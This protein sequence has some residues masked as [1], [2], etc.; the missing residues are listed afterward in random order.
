MLRSIKEI[1]GY[2]IH[3]EDGKFGTVSD[4]YFDDEHWMVRYLVVDTGKWLPGRKVLLPPVVLDRPR[5][6]KKELPVK[7]T[8]KKIENSPPITMDEPV[9]R[10]FEKELN[11]Y[12]QLEPYWVGGVMAGAYSSNAN[13][14]DQ[15]GAAHSVDTPAPEESEGDMDLR[16]CDEVMGY[17]IDA[18]DGEMGH[19]EDFI[20]DDEVWTI[21]HMVVDTRNWLPGKKVLVPVI[22]IETIDWPQTRLSVD[23]TREEI[24]NGPEYDPSKPVSREYE[25]V[26]YDYHG[27]PKYWKEEQ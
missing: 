13:I 5:W 18:N 11:R 3:A 22:W 24:K 10:R 12:F 1:I 21:R 20:L 15:S 8:R 6:S 27:K 17:R 7:L 4:F 16:S 2:D 26:L 23:L 19:V 14:G 9:S 25:E